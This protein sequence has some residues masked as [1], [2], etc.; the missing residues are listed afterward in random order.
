MSACIDGW[1]TSYLSPPKFLTL[2]FNS[3]DF[4]LYPPF[5]YSLIKLEPTFGKSTANIIK[6]YQFSILC[7]NSPF[8][9]KYFHGATSEMTFDCCLSCVSHS[10]VL[11]MVWV[12]EPYIPL[13]F[14]FVSRS[15]K[16]QDVIILD[17]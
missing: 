12:Q 5:I 13:K 14:F 9:P 6:L 17:E 1:R 4:K 11:W 10:I 8:L 2:D 15:A 16:N 3:Y 7:E